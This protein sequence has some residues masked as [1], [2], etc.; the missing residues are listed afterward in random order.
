MIISMRRIS[1]KVILLN[2]VKKVGKSGEIVEVSDGYARNFLFRQKLAVPLTDKSQDVLNQ[3]KQVDAKEKEDIKEEAQI[4]K[5]KIE[6]ITL[7]FYLKKG[8]NE[9]VFG[10]ISTKQIS[11]EFEKKYN[12]KVDKRKIKSSALSELG[13]F[14]ITISLHK[15][16]DAIATIHI[17]EQV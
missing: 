11:D 1:M 12:I 13:V 17:K 14:K 4:L 7:M 10:S 16:V 2:D 15:D 6:E 5:N 9:K 3:Q 8:A